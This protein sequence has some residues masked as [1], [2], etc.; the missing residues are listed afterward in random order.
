MLLA[1]S[2]SARIRFLQRMGV[3]RFAYSPNRCSTIVPVFPEES[4][5]L[6][7][8]RRTSVSRVA[9]TPLRTATLRAVG[10]GIKV[11]L[12]LLVS[13][14]LMGSSAEAAI[15]FKPRP[16]LAETGL[17]V[18]GGRLF[19][20][21][22]EPFSG[23]VVRSLELRTGTVVELLRVPATMEVTALEAGGGRVA[24]ASEGSADALKEQTRVVELFPS[25]G[26]PPAEL[27]LATIDKE[28]GCG[29]VVA[30][31]DV[32]SNGDILVEEGTRPCGPEAA[33]A[34]LILR[35][36]GRAGS[37][38]LLRR[39]SP[40]AL[41]T[42]SI[43]EAVRRLEGGRLL[44]FTER[45][46]SVLSLTTGETHPLPTASRR[47]LLGADLSPSGAALLSEESR[48]AG[49]RSLI[50]LFPAGDELGQPSTLSERR[51]FSDG[52]F[53]GEKVVELVEGLARRRITVRAQ[54]GS[55]QLVR[56]GSTRSDI[57]FLACDE[58]YLALG[59]IGSRTE[60]ASIEVL[61]LP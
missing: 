49:G 6:P 57:E 41:A 32:S 15:V 31:R 13:W 18:D 25:G 48:G 35:R 4:E 21:T 36:M 37:Q 5:G 50:K 42:V 29:N 9:R 10:A 11:A 20:V 8:S 61:P 56:R 58:S 46:A 19:Y 47:P 60:A 54:G 59:T 28:E 43:G 14:T 34:E 7:A 44:S 23:Q 51:A 24:V 40:D 17:A 39:P 1:Q 2:G 12:A 45:S 30:L 52:F 33:P 3:R 16:T 27:A 38:E 53:C 26:A 22:G 55:P